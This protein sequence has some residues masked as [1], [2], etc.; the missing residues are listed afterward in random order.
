MFQDT[1]SKNKAVVG[2]RLVALTKA[3]AQTKNSWFDGSIESV[4]SRLRQCREFLS[5]LRE[6]VNID[7]NFLSVAERIESDQQRLEVFRESLLNGAEFGRESVGPII[8]GAFKHLPNNAQRWIVLESKKFLRANEDTWSDKNE[9]LV[10]AKYHVND[11][12]KSMTPRHRSLVAS[13]FLSEVSQ[14]VPQKREVRQARAVAKDVEI[15]D[16]LLFM[17]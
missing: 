6:A 11:Q 10:R 9:L 15:P 4:D 17:S 12:T 3:Y 16:Q 1:A 13:A 14:N 8:E 2:K 5:S 7:S